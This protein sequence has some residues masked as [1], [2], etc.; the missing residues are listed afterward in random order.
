MANICMPGMTMAGCRA[1][2]AS[3]INHLVS[4]GATVLPP[5]VRD[6]LLI[7]L[8]LS[9]LGLVLFLCRLAWHRQ[10]PRYRWTSEWLGHGGA[11]AVGMILMTTLM[12]GWVSTIG[13]AWAYLI[14]YG[15]LAL[16]FALHA[17]VAGEAAIRTDDLWHVFVQLSMVYMFGILGQSPAVALTAAFLVFYGALTVDGLRDALQKAGPDAA[18]RGDRAPARAAGTIGHLAISVSMVIMFVVMQWPA[19]FS[20]AA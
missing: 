18:L 16:V 9:F 1:F 13:P 4:P 19:L 10:I 11:H 5:G 14:I 12:L 7:A 17:L 6:M 8:G 3:S 15:A 20:G 2:A